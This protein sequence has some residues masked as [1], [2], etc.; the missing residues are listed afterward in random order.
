[1]DPNDFEVVISTSTC[2]LQ[3]TIAALSHYPCYNY[4]MKLS[5]PNPDSLFSHS[6]SLNHH[7]GN[8]LNQSD[9]LQT[10]FKLRKITAI[11]ALNIVDLHVLLLKLENDNSPGMFLLNIGDSE[12]FLKGK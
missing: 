2:R 12:L 7:I 9:L 8:C 5:L 11:C 4:F 3:R 1:M 6:L 10:L